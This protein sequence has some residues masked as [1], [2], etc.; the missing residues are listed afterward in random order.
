[1]I[2]DIVYCTQ[3]HDTVT[4]VRINN[5][6]TS[7]SQTRVGIRFKL[8]GIYEFKEGMAFSG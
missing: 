3:Q 2:R 6:I 4:E 1:M 8:K 5:R 7:I